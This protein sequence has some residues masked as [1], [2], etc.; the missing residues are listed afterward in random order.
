MKI[1]AL[2]VQFLL[3]ATAAMAQTTYT[4]PGDFATPQG[5][6]DAI[7]DGDTIVVAPGTYLGPLIVHRAVR[8]VSSDGPD[9]T[10]IVGNV[11]G[12]AVFLGQPLGD[13]Q[14]PLPRVSG[15]RFEGFTVRNGVHS[16]LWVLNCEA[17]IVNCVIRDNNA[18]DEYAG[19]VTAFSADATFDRCLIIDNRGGDGAFPSPTNPLAPPRPGF[20]GAMVIRSADVHISNSLIAR[21]EGGRGRDGFSYIT[22]TLPGAAGGQGA[23]RAF[24]SSQVTI[25][26]STFAANQGGLSGTSPPPFPPTRVPAFHGLAVEPTSSM[27]LLDSIIWDH[28]GQSV[29]GTATA[30]HCCIEGGLPGPGNI[31]A[32]PQFSNS[33]GG[34]YHLSSTS[35]CIEAGRVSI[36]TATDIDGHPRLL[37]AASDIGFDEYAPLA[38]GSGEDL[39]LWSTLNGEGSLLHIK[40]VSGFDTLVQRM[41]SPSGSLNGATPFLVFQ[42][43][44]NGTTPTGL[45]GYPEIHFDPNQSALLYDGN[46]LGATLAPGGVTFGPVIVPPNFLTGQTIRYQALAVTPSAANGIFAASRA[47]D[48]YFF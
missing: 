26:H 22:L 45:P 16:G 24:F 19:G 11:V 36:S 40:P 46:L 42:V 3:V 27:N 31:T 38:A 18:T 43:M 2:I 44:S 35:P 9:V 32:S 1:R 48:L 8:I 15:I 34:D 29:T 21:N 41:E 28:N 20:P 37:G 13:A 30:S 47:D 25:E 10:H 14:G 5:A 23:L 12:P 33:I 6:V 17:E 4:V 7:A 39:E